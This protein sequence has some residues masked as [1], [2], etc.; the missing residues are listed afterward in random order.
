M[1][2]FNVK[3]SNS[4]KFHNLTRLRLASQGP[5]ACRANLVDEVQHDR[6]EEEKRQFTS[7]LGPH[8]SLMLPSQPIYKS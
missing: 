8:Q 5:K 7:S 3:G 1:T 2:L 6:R 4:F